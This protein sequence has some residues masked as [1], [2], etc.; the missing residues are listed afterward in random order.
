[1]GKSITK[2][3]REYFAKMEEGVRA[4]YAKL[5]ERF[6]FNPEVLREQIIERFHRA[7]DT[8]KNFA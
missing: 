2:A 5:L 4:K 6:A 8:E 1:M 3:V 7:F